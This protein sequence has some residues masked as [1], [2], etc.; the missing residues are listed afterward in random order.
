MTDIQTYT[1]SRSCELIKNEDG[2]FRVETVET[3]FEILSKLF[4]NQIIASIK[5]MYHLNNGTN[6]V[7]LYAQM[8]SG[9]TGVAAAV[10][11]LFRKNIQPTIKIINDIKQNLDRLTLDTT[12]DNDDSNIL[13]ICPINDNNILSQHQR[14]LNQYYKVVKKENI[15]TI[16]QLKQLIKSGNGIHPF[17]KIGQRNLLI[18]DESHFCQDEISPINNTRLMV[19]KLLSDIGLQL[20]GLVNGPYDVKVVNISATPFS[21]LVSLKYSEI[22][23]RKALVTLE[24]GL[25]YYGIKDMYKADKIF[26]ACNFKDIDEVYICDLL[27]KYIYDDGFGIIRLHDIAEYDMI[28]E[29]INIYYTSIKIHKIH[30]TNNN[31]KQVKDIISSNPGKL[32]L[33]FICNIMRA[34]Y[35]LNTENILFVHEYSARPDMTYQGLPGRCC[36]YNKHEHNVD[37]YCN[38]D[39]IRQYLNLQIKHKDV[40]FSTIPAGSKNVNGGVT[41]NLIECNWRALDLQ[42]INLSDE[43][44]ELIKPYKNMRGHKYVKLWNDLY[45]KIHQIKLKY[46]YN[47]GV[48]STIGDI[49]DKLRLKP[50]VGAQHNKI[51]LPSNKPSVLNRWNSYTS[52]RQITD[53]PVPFYGLIK[54]NE[55]YS[56]ETLQS[57]NKKGVYYIAINLV[58]EHP[59]YGKLAL[60]S[61]VYVEN[62]VD[63]KFTA[64]THAISIKKNCIFHPETVLN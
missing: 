61:A 16:P 23:Q 22:S 8:Q 9:K 1:T 28:E 18:I 19:Y 60:L 42:L 27:D 59:D 54:D 58:E 46:K 13:F 47:N 21:E 24:N 62:T 2:S 4:A 37:I 50:L 36:G 51:W 40:S 49:V 3:K 14:E 31:T 57:E 5:I 15:L 32:E 55:R 44:I 20:N 41:P 39:H 52:P 64:K 56:V 43:M 48:I 26:S 63:T 38:I 17:F 30:S 7:I 12:L 45:R 6:H 33:I 29:L 35:Q 34:S 53:N 25:N 11:Y 10:A